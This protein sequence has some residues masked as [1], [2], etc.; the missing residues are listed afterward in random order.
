L[1]EQVWSPRDIGVNFRLTEDGK[2]YLKELEAADK[3]HSQS[4]GLNLSSSKS[5]IGINHP[6]A[7]RFTSTEIMRIT[8]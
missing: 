5:L 6:L 2:R 1:F 7:L 3:T 8:D 4:E